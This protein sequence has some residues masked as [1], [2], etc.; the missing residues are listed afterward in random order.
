[1]SGPL[2]DD[3]QAALGAS[4]TLDRELGGGGMS[5]V[6]L[7][8]EARLGRKVVIKVLSPELAAG[9][10]GER[11]EREIRLAAQLA[12]P[13]IVPLLAAGDANGLPYY[14]MPFVEGESLRALLAAKGSLP[15]NEIAGILRDIARALAYAHER[16]IVHRDI[17]PENVLLAS[18][19]AVVTDFGIAKAISASRTDAGEATLTHAGTSIGTPSYMA[20][21]QALG[22]PA[23]D[24]RADIY[25]FGCV[26][27]ELLTGVSPFHGR[28]IHK[29]IAA[30]MSERPADVASLRPDCPPSLAAFVMRCLEKDPDH[31]PQSALEVL[32][33]LEAVTTPSSGR[34]ET[35]K[36]TQSPQKPS[37]LRALVVPAVVVAVA[38]VLITTWRAGRTPESST[39]STGLRS[40]AVLPFA[41]ADGDTANA[42]FAGGISEE[43]ATS[44]SKVAG[45]R[46][47]ARNSSFTS[48]G[49]QVDEHEAGK[50]LNVD[51]LLTGSVRRSGPQM[52]V[53]ARLIAVKD[54]SL[55]WSDQF[56]REVKD[57]FALQDEITRAIVS[58][59][60]GHL[61]SASH[62][63]DSGAVAG[64]PGTSNLDAHDLYMRA[65]FNL[66]R[67]AVPA[68]VN[69]FERAISLDTTYARA[70]SGLSAALE[71]TPYFAGLPADSVRA[72][73]MT[74]AQRALSLDAS[75]AEAHT[76]M[77]LAYQHAHQWADAEREHR[78]AVE[79]DPNDAA[80]HVQFA[81]LLLSTGRTTEA[82][83]EARR[84]EALDPF[85]PVVASWV[86]HISLILGNTNE[87]LTAAKRGLELDSTTAPA[88]YATA[89]AYLATGQN[90]AAVRTID[91]LPNVLPWP[92][93]R[94][95]IHA[96]TGDRETAMKIAHEIETR[97]RVWS[98]QTALAWTYMGLNDTTRA[99]NALE[100]ATDAH[101]MWFVWYTLGS[102]IYDP[103]RGSARFAALV[104][105]VGLPENIF[106]RSG[107]VSQSH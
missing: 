80:A 47:V 82:L 96:T 79:V 87:A 107:T 15:L 9:V 54:E 90:Q 6:F 37:R 35:I 69:Y 51:A 28:P 93:F 85:S 100:R 52:R 44:L 45:L 19:A 73:A 22:D 2:R 43:L 95:F 20:P 50:V 91:R 26:A 63:L 77:A 39:E 81:R 31:R 17:K 18:G 12:H 3:L 70:Y 10:S 36:A 32:P 83:E 4:Y 65:Q 21:E 74:A 23:T 99:L 106:T 48:S 34:D 8:D 86:S 62:G 25:A 33:A 41:I 27:Y 75:L 24:S 64:N 92:G 29:L 66:R 42:Y 97:P 40:V 30:H 105:R 103:V 68:A 49:R 67:R 55:L 16:G 46:V 101:E 89:N 84:A 1:M 58:A 13:S 53:N 71:M 98:A 11:F 56:D 61:G 76:S 102:R 38:A 78:R 59:I 88:I 14:T 57:V 94:A 104:H 7:A 72:E 5:R 60:R